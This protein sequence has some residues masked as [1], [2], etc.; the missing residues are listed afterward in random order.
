LILELLN[1]RGESG[2]CEK[3]IE[4][5]QCSKPESKDS[6]RA[7]HRI[8]EQSI[9]KRKKSNGMLMKKAKSVVLTNDGR[10]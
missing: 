4:R 7:D 10:A 6:L 3:E 5:I 9:W 2:C 1:K 8:R